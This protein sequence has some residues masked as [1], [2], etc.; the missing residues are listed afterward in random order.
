MPP[1]DKRK[2]YKV[3][4]RVSKPFAR[5]AH[6]AFGRD[7]ELERKRAAE[8][9]LLKPHLA[10]HLRNLVISF[11]MLSAAPYYLPAALH[12]VL[13]IIS[14]APLLASLELRTGIFEPDKLLA[15]LRRKRQL[16]RLVLDCREIEVL[17]GDKVCGCCF[18]EQTVV[19]QVTWSAS[20]L[21]KFLAPL[22]HLKVLEVISLQ[23]DS[24]FIFPPNYLPRLKSLTLTDSNPGSISEIL[25][26]LGEGDPPSHSLTL[27][28]LH[29]SLKSS[30]PLDTPQLDRNTLGDLFVTLAP[31]LKSLSLAPPRSYILPPTTLHPLTSLR[32]ITLSGS[33]LASFDFLPSLPRSLESVTFLGC[34]TI[35]AFFLGDQLLRA[36]LLPRLRFIRTGDGDGTRWADE[37]S[38]MDLGELSREL[39][40]RRGIE[41]AHL[42]DGKWTTDF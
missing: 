34:A 26:L 19:H 11:D 4:C 31:N 24:T 10:I 33:P 32:S 35:I 5:L 29:L 40:E 22:R 1:A 27:S 36:G 38:A 6:I 2:Q 28:A 15:V 8:S 9:L 14:A 20:R 12:N 39:R 41:W 25:S 7:V 3:L 17:Y 30:N 18:R 23:P 16:V 42:E 13:S 21:L 37:R